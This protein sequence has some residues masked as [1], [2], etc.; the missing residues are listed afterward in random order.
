LEKAFFKE[1][2]PMKK[3]SFDI[4]LSQDG[5][6]KGF[7][8]EDEQT[9]KKGIVLIIHGM[10]EHI[11]RYD[12]FASFLSTQGFV[13]CG[14]DQ[15]GHGK[16]LKSLDNIGYM[17]DIDN[18][19]ILV[20]DVYEVS[21]CIKSKYPD[22]PFYLFGHSMGSFVSQR[23]IEIYGTTID[24]V[25]L[26]GSS[27]N[28]GFAINAGLQLAKIITKF[29]GRRY[30]SK[31]MHNLSFGAYNKAFTP[32]RTDVDWLSRDEKTVDNYA[33][34]DLCGN[35]FTVSFY[36]D[37]LE[38]FKNIYRNFEIIPNELPVYIF[39][40][41]KDP[42]G[43]QGKAVTKLFQRFIK[44]GIKN[45]EFK[46]YP[47]GRHEMLNELNKDEVYNDVLNWLNKQIKNKQ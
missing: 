9:P 5:N 17:S 44:T 43:G 20:S 30:R 37:L 6:V 31:L 12:A 24:G 45:V 33:N 38:G 26:S 29:K 10:A 42:V 1:E 16:S 3:V 18:F 25:I 46:L 39:S 40:G 32:N 36:K 41:D 8:W 13:V 23:F 2:E 14:Y 27:L 19:K 11:D 34:D 47:E 4:N 15:R 28:K 22:L 35:I 7:I 21:N